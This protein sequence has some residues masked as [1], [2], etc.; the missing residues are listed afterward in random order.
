MYECVLKTAI[1]DQKEILW[2]ALYVDQIK[3]IENFTLE[4][5]L[6]TKIFATNYKCE[7]TQVFE[8]DF[9]SIEEAFPTSENFVYLLDYRTLEVG[10]IVWLEDGSYIVEEIVNSYRPSGNYDIVEWNGYNYNNKNTFML[11]HDI[12][13][14]KVKGMDKYYIWQDYNYQQSYLYENCNKI[15]QKN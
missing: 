7:H 5:D 9:S 14:F 3:V 4:I 12:T 13:K 8:N 1:N 2:Q 11:G 6:V 10:M 15:V